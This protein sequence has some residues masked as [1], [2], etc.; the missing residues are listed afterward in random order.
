M[1][2]ISIKI[3]LRLGV[4]SLC[5]GQFLHKEWSEKEGI[6]VVLRKMIEEK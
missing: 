1:V 4:N 2:K 3:P 6:R 5:T